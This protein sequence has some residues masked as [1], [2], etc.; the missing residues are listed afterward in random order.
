MK[1][2][3]LSRM[4]ALTLAAG[5]FMTVMPWQVRATE[6]EQAK[7]EIATEIKAKDEKA[8]A[9]KSQ[10]PNDSLKDSN[11]AD[12]AKEVMPADKA[13]VEKEKDSKAPKV[14]ETDK[15]ASKLEKNEDAE[16]VSK[17][18][19]SAISKAMIGADR[20]V[21]ESGTGKVEFKLGKFED[22]KL[23]DLSE[24]WYTEQLVTSAIDIDVSGNN[25]VLNK[26]YIVLR[27]PKTNKIKD[28][29]FIDSQAGRTERYEDDDYKYVKYVYDSMSGGTHYT[30]SFYFK[31]DAHNAKNDDTIEVTASLYKDGDNGKDGN[32]FQELKQTYRAKTLGFELFSTQYNYDSMQQIG[33][34]QTNNDGHKSIVKGWVEK[35]SDTTTFE[36]KPCVAPVYASVAPQAIKGISESVGL[37]YPKNI[38]FV[39]EFDNTEKGFTFEGSWNYWGVGNADIK[40]ELSADEKVLTIICQNPTMA[41][42]AD[43]TNNYRQSLQVK[44][45]V[46]AKAVTLNKDISVNISAYKN[47]DKD[48]N[49]GEL[50]GTRKEVYHFK[51]EPFSRGGNFSCSKIAYGDYNIAEEFAYIYYADYYYMNN[52][53]YKGAF[54]M[55]EKGVPLKGLLTNWNTG[56]SFANPWKDGNVTKVKA[57]FNKLESDGIYFKST[58]LWADC[59][60]SKNPENENILNAIKSA[61]S[62]GNVKLYGI[63][64]AGNETLISDKVEYNKAIN[65]DDK[66]GLYKE[67][68]YRFDK[69]LVLD[70]FHLYVNDRVW[71]VD[72]ELKSFSNLKDQ[73]KAYSSSLSVTI[74]DK[75][76]KPVNEKEKKYTNNTNKFFRVRALHP[77]VDEFISAEQVVAYSNEGTFNYLIGP[78]LPKVRHDISTYGADLKE[79]KNLKVI[80]LIPAGFEFTGEIKRTDNDGHNW[81]AEVSDPVIKTVKNYKGTGKTAVIADF[82]NVPIER[83]YPLNLVL[84]ATKTAQRGKNKFVNYMVYD[85]NDFIRPL[86]SD[87]HEHDYVDTLDLDDDGDTQ[88]VF[89]QKQTN[90][91]FIPPLELVM[92]NKVCFEDIKD[93]IAIV[94]DLGSKTQ[95]KINIFNNSIQTI[96]KLSILDVLP[97]VGDHA[98]AP[99]E[100]GEYPARNSSFATP[101]I[102]SVEAAND[103][104]VNE[105]F[106]FY[107]QLSAQGNDLASVRDGQWV[108]KEEITD[109]SKVKSVKAV[110]KEGQ[111]LKSKESIDIILPVSMPKNTSLEEGTTYA[112][113]SAAFSTDDQNYTEGN[114]TQLSFVKYKV[115]GMAFLDL[116]EDGKY[117]NKDKIVPGIKVNLLK[118]SPA[119]STPSTNAENRSARLDE[120]RDADNANIPEGYELAKDLDG[121]AITTTTNQ[122]GKYSFDVYQR[123]SYMVQFELGN[124]QSFSAKSTAGSEDI[125][126][127]SIEASTAS[128][129]SA[130]STQGKLNPSK[131]KMIRSVAIKQVWKIKITKVD[132]KDESK[133][134]AGSEFALIKVNGEQQATANGNEVEFKN[135]TTNDDGE[136]TFENVP[137]GSYKVREIRAPKG[138]ELPE[139]PETA[140]PEL[141]AHMNPASVDVTVTNKLNKARLVV[142]KTDDSKEA[143]PLAGVEFKLNIIGELK[144]ETNSNPAVT[145]KQ[146]EKVTDKSATGD[147]SDVTNSVNTTEQTEWTGTTDKDGKIIFKDLPLGEYTLE[148]TKGL[149]G[150]E[151]L[152]KPMDITLNTPY[153]EKNSDN[154]TKTVKVVNKKSIIPT[155]PSVP[156]NPEYVPSTQTEPKK[157]KVGV[158]TKTGELANMASGF[159]LVMLA[160]FA[161][162]TVN[163][164]KK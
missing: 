141:L 96:N 113:N 21:T 97:Y 132:A 49:N 5:I 28:L 14:S 20:A 58:R 27:V 129:K 17:D 164:R 55:N 12:K 163:K 123:A 131:K 118:P 48:G 72:D 115:E 105:K 111:E 89:M 67:V 35:D 61:C 4:C 151:K 19:L 77:V 142:L 126:T 94:S 155:K 3:R 145:D 23:S 31:F 147:A 46:K 154:T 70:N 36:G 98:I 143:K 110:L 60:D 44:A 42:S 41:G 107:Y 57:I 64:N 99:N 26:P 50:I 158:V 24:N 88:E 91:K 63:D 11:I 71:F 138:Y 59:Y 144:T 137:Y 8:S 2:S 146:A 56:S 47:V 9:D 40:R 43:W 69:P 78:M 65:I 119:A 66:K 83:Y 159:G 45:F 87:K 10:A 76:D 124:G 33:Y 85:D 95:H 134:L 38:K 148:E 92:N 86:G 54:S 68:V 120:D 51:P 52:K 80:T 93:E 130:V 25:Y 18:D 150:Y 117:N 79:I 149:N 156:S 162:L 101:L 122:E 161:A 128:E 127:N 153:D 112:I 22:S 114:K 30:Y 81:T 39:L 121:N 125:G 139:Q 16:L 15:Q 109:W 152:D 116:D 6:T 140:V 82:G 37:E 90:V 135:V 136:A 104:S 106:S 157:I 29:K 100:K 108:K 103:K 102:S 13:N 84:R 160:A 1:M 73:E 53:L 75:D 133:K 34:L 7:T 62:N 74:L 32:L